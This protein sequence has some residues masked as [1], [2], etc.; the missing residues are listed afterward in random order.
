MIKCVV[1]FGTRGVSESTDPRGNFS[2][3]TIKLNARC[4]R[5]IRLNGGRQNSRLCNAAIEYT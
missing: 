2:Y 3:R 4:V 5:A 1:S